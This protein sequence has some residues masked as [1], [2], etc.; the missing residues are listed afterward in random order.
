MQNWK[1]L[2]FIPILAL[3]SCKSLRPFTQQL[4]DQYQWTEN[5]LKQIQFY[6]SKDVVLQRDLSDSQ[7]RIVTGKIR[8]INGREVEEVL[9]R[10][11]TPGVLSY[12]PE[13]NRFG[14]QFENGADR[15]LMFGPNPN[16][17]ERYTLLF[18]SSE[19]K[20]RLAYITYEGLQWKTPSESGAAYLMVD[21]RKISKTDVNSRTAK[22]IKIK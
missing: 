20:G 14:V 19:G 12:L 1:I 8:T 10:K 4:Y 21:M 13:S 22:G 16:L 5:E 7:T 3:T 9:M 6:L 18:S 11:G 17:N 15:Q 2:I